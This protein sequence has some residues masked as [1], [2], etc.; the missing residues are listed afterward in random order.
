M[1]I[2]FDKITSYNADN[3][4]SWANLIDFNYFKLSYPTLSYV[5]S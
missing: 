5:Y 3:N 4:Q 2:Y 1:V